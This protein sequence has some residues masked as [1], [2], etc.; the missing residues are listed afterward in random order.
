MDDKDLYRPSLL[1]RTIDAF[2]D[3]EHTAARQLVDGHCTPY[4]EVY[5]YSGFQ[6]HYGSH[7]RYGLTMLIATSFAILGLVFR[8]FDY[9]TK[10]NEEKVA[11]HAA[12]SNVV[13]AS[14]LPSH[15]RDRVSF[16]SLCP[17]RVCKNFKWGFWF[18]ATHR[19][20]IIIFF[21]LLN[22]CLKRKE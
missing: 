9:Q 13:L 16:M 2:E 10:K 1:N 3:P 6:K 5:A 8:L 7:F 11:Q 15:I 17:C 18:L 12:R 19:A 22:R 4:L 21:S 20:L 14:L